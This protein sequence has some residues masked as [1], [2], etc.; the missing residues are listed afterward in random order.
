MI[1]CICT[2]TVCQHIQLQFHIQFTCAL[3]KPRQCTYIFI[4]VQNIYMYLYI[5]YLSFSTPSF[6]ANL[7]ILAKWLAYL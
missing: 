2:Y 6:L 3:S 7:L 4:Y 5:F 1:Y